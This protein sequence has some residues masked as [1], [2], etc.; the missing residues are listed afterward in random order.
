MEKK[1]RNF[2]EW[3][4]ALPADCYSCSDLSGGIRCVQF[5]RNA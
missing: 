4:D 1:K 5:A 2:V 3:G